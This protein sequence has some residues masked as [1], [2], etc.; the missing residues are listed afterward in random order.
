[1]SLLEPGITRLTDWQAVDDSERDNPARLLGYG[2][3][4]QQP[5]A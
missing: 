5:P 1:M 4:A 3:L 2:A